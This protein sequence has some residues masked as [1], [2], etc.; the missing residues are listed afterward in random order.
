MIE[1]E[2]RKEK[3]RRKEG[4]REEEEERR[5]KKKGRKRKEV[6]MKEKLRQDTLHNSV[7]INKDNTPTQARQKSRQKVTG[8]VELQR[9][10]R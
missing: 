6:M 3:K 10:Q 4:G 2:R 5:R 1:T 7:I 8:I 9:W